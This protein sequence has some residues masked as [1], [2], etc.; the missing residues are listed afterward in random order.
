MKKFAKDQKVRDTYE[1]K[2]WFVDGYDDKGNVSCTRMEN[3]TRLY[4][5]FIEAELQDYEEYIEQIAE[6]WNQQPKRVF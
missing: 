1:G 6:I 5:T 3:E 2:E 4:H